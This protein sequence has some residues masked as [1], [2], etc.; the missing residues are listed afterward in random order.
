MNDIT[1]FIDA[2]F[3]YGSSNEEL[4]ELR[5][6]QGKILILSAKQTKPNTC[7][8]SVLSLSRIP[9]DLLK[10]FEISVPRHIRVERVRKIIN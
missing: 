10:H 2:S 5:A 1:A 4:D 9:R 7:A 8:I 3:V 6:E